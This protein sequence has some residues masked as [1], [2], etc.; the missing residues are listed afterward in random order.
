MHGTVC[1]LYR[2]IRREREVCLL[3]GAG[4]EQLNRIQ[5]AQ[6]VEDV[7]VD[8]IEVR[9]E[10]GSR[11]E[12]SLN[13]RERHAPMRHHGLF[14]AEH[15]RDGIGPHTLRQADTEGQNVQKKSRQPVRS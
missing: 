5:A 12:A 8:E 10:Q 15:G 11:P 1:A 4:I 3:T 7:K 14:D 13:L 6:R 2:E 9:V